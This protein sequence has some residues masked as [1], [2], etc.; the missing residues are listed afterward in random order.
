MTSPNESSEVFLGTL[1]SELDSATRPAEEFLALEAAVRKIL[2]YYRRGRITADVTASA[3]SRMVIRTGT[4]TD[5]TVGATSGRWYRR[6]SGGAWVPATPPGPG[7]TDDSIEAS[8]RAA[9]TIARNLIQGLGPLAAPQVTDRPEPTGG[10]RNV[11][12]PEFGSTL[13][14]VVAQV[15]DAADAPAPLDE[16]FSYLS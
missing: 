10:V 6:P 14:E 7:R 2:G 5:W 8:A 9:L 16:D 13:A 1:R 3:L 4:G 12:S 11:D 15:D